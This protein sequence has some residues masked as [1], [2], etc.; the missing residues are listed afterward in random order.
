VDHGTAVVAPKGGQTYTVRQVL[1]D[2]TG[3]V[4]RLILEES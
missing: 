2:P 4:Y 1:P 3:R